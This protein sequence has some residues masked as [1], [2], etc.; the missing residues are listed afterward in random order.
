MSANRL[1]RVVQVAAL[2][3]LLPLFLS[4]CAKPPTILRIYNWTD[5]LSEDLIREFEAKHKCRIVQEYFESNEELIERL[6][7]GDA[8]FDL[9]VPSSYVA[10]RMYR[11]G[12]IQALDRTRLAPTLKNLDALV[13]KKF[14]ESALDYSVPYMMSHTVLAYRKSLVPNF[15]PSWTMLGREDLRGKTSLLD[16]YRE[17][18]GSA[19][20]TLG[21][22]VNTKNED[23]VRAAA[24]KALE[25]KA[26]ASGFDNENYKDGLLNG[27]IVL[28]QG[29]V[30]DLFQIQHENPDIEIVIP[31]EGTQLAIDS[32]AIPT[33]AVNVD[34]AYDFI[35]FVHE[36]A[37]AAR[38]TETIQ[39]VCPN[40][41]SYELVPEGL[42]D[43]KCIFPGEAYIV[44]HM[45][46]LLDLGDA[47]SMYEKYWDIIRNKDSLD[48]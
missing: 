29:Y 9:V 30:G 2:G 46:L 15:E 23:E 5:Y 26:L 14:P 39:Y 11:A 41:P 1:I 18:I 31:R 48:D 33:G 16:D 38:N 21:H 12:L 22:N 34:L 6:Q 28:A 20:R 37:N 17:V 3:A 7:K 32:F 10:G 44:S 13:V 8:A 27:S 45:N 40:K 19:L 47:Q 4:S 25:W 42:R 35:N 36:P 43:N 24:A